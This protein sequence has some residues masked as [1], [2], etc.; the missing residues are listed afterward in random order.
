MIWSFEAATAETL[1][2]V[3]SV[4][5]FVSRP[6]WHGRRMAGEHMLILGI[7][8]PKGIKKYVAAAFSQRMRENQSCHV[9]TTIP[10]GKSNALETILPG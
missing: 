7:T 4:F 8:S 5:P 2:W 3:K 6:S 10:D 1:C 9:D